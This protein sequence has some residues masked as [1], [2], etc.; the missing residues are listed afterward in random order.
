MSAGTIR[1]GSSTP[2][3]KGWI[4]RR[5]G[6]S[7]WR[8]RRWGVWL[9]AGRPSEALHLRLS[10]P[11]PIEPA[12][13]DGVSSQ[14]RGPLAVVDFE[15]GLQ[16]HR[17]FPALQSRGVSRRVTPVRIAVPDAS[18]CTAASCWRWTEPASRRSTTRIATSPRSSL[19]E[20]IRRAEERLEDYLKRLDEG[21]VEDGA[22]RAAR[23]RRSTRRT[24]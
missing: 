6:F 10:E 1:R 12:T 11:G 5:R 9:C 21:D 15:T 8:R 3:S 7:G 14:H 18:T 17:R 23:A 20:F 22:T 4:L 13:G 2:S 16:D 19:R 24:S